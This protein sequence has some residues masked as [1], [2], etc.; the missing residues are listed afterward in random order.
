MEIVR[1]RKKDGLYFNLRHKVVCQYSSYAP[2]NK[3]SSK[4]VCK[5]SLQF[6]GKALHGHGEIYGTACLALQEAAKQI[7]YR[8]VRLFR[9]A[10]HAFYRAGGKYTDKTD[11]YYSLVE[12]LGGN[13]DYTCRH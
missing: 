13:D 2:L 9:T 12:T 11:Y 8:H 3:G 1:S 10:F 6:F 7:Q 4:L 5:Q